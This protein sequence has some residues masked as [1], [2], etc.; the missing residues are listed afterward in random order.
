MIDFNGVPFRPIKTQIY[1]CQHGK[2]YYKQRQ[3]KSNRLCL[4]STKKIGCSAHI[5]VKEYN[6]YPDFA[7]TEREGSMKMH[8]I[9]QLKKS[10]QANITEALIANVSQLKVEEQYF[11]LYCIGSLLR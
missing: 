8:E 9:R 7:I 10:K 5:I 6:L 2:Q 3:R 1:D 11:V 4:Q